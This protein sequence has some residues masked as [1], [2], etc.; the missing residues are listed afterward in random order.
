MHEP[1]LI[2]RHYKQ[3]KMKLSIIIPVYNEEKTIEKIINIIGN[4]DLK[5]VKK[6]SKA[7][8]SPFRLVPYAFLILS[9]IALKNNNL[10]NIGI[11]LPSLL[12]GIIIG[13]YST[14]DII[15]KYK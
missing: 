11:Y 3:N 1:N 10:L 7:G 12:I 6:G 4:V 15:N 5:D 14:R 13:Y 8:F 2:K 9:F